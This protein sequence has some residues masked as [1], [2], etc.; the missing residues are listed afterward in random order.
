MRPPR[1]PVSL[2]PVVR[3]DL[4]S[5]G[6]MRGILQGAEGP[7]ITIG[8]V[9]IRTYSDA[10]RT[11][12][13]RAG[14]RWFGREGRRGWAGGGKASVERGLRGPRGAGASVVRG[15]NAARTWGADRSGRDWFL[16]LALSRICQGGLA[17]IAKPRKSFLS[18]WQA[19]EV[20]R[21]VRRYRSCDLKRPQQA[22]GP[23]PPPG[24]ESRSGRV[25]GRRASALSGTRPPAARLGACCPSLAALHGEGWR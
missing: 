25:P 6:R 3:R 4:A 16:V 7:G 14:R 2:P 24:G 19:G 5:G 1:H 11:H 23:S 13:Q 20:A 12:L 17:K 22:Q 18:R 8:G 9:G 21:W 15:P 10:D